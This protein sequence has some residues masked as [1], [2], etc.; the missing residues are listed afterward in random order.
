M[1]KN[2]AIPNLI[3]SALS[4]PSFIKSD[5]GI[6][7]EL[8]EKI[9]KIFDLHK[10]TRSKR[11]QTERDLEEI[12]ST[13]KE[14]IENFD[15]KTKEYFEEIDENEL[16]KEKIEET[17]NEMKKNHASIG[18]KIEVKKPIVDKRE[19]EPN[20]YF[21]AKKHHTIAEIVY[22]KIESYDKDIDLSGQYREIKKKEGLP[23]IFKLGVFVTLEPYLVSSLLIAS[24]EEDLDYIMNYREI[25]DDVS[26]LF[27]RMFREEY[28]EKTG[29]KD[30]KF[31]R[32][33]I[34]AVVN[35]PGF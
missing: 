30:L 31:N 24:R 5:V 4:T 9:E 25:L 19:I 8:P 6:Q 29:L 23:E 17:V 18:K 16:K 13:S 3:F 27:S 7:I 10:K 34:K 22:E 1:N 28:K 2:I 26:Y 33:E 15:S 35:A 21:M 32:K 14:L 12:Y 11:R 20:I